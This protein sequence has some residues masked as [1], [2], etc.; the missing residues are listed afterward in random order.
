MVEN[1][2]KTTKRPTRIT[3]KRKEDVC[4]GQKICLRI[5]GMPF[6]YKRG[7]DVAPTFKKWEK[8]GCYI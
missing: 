3:E 4:R 5:D 6:T 1:S 8:R 2:Y 7:K